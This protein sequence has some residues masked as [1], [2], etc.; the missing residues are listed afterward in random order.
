MMPLSKA[1]PD[2]LRTTLQRLV[3]ASV[4]GYYNPYVTFE[5]PA[6][7]PP[8]QWWMSPDLLTVDDTPLMGELDGNTLRALSKWE[9]IN[10]YSLNVH[11]IRELLV[12]VVRRVHTPGFEEMSEFF[13]HFTGEE[14]EHMWFFA[15]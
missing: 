15:T 5:W 12:E 11:G 6:E 8:E 4:S 14:N 9:S 7:L 10:F 13:H 1:D 2:T 3:A